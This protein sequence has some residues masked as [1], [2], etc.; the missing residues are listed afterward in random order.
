MGGRKAGPAERAKAD[1]ET[2]ATAGR[3]AHEPAI[4]LWPP[5]KTDIELARA[6]GV[7]KALTACD[8]VARH[9]L[10]SFNAWSSVGVHWL[11]HDV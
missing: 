9:G 1:F 8:K 10:R 11:C 6:S 5:F 7:L 3:Y 4:R 2:T